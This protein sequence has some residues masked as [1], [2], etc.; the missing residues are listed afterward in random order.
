MAKTVA[1]AAVV[2]P[3]S[4]DGALPGRRRRR[5]PLHLFPL[6]RP[7]RRTR[8]CGPARS[9]RCSS[10][11]PPERR[12]RPIGR[13]HRCRSNSSR[14]ARDLRRPAGACRSTGPRTNA[15]TATAS[16]PLS[17]RSGWAGCVRANPSA[18]PHQSAIEAAVW[19]DGKLDVG[20][21]LECGI[22]GRRRWTTIEASTK[23]V[24]PATA[25][26]RNAA[27]RGRPPGGTA[28][29]PTAVIASTIWVPP[30][31]VPTLVTEIGVRWVTT[32]C[33]KASS[34]RC[35]ALCASTWVTSQPRP[36]ITASTRRK[37]ANTSPTTATPVRGRAPATTPGTGPGRVISSRPRVCTHRGDEYRIAHDDR[38]RGPRSSADAVA[39][40]SMRCTS[41][42]APSPISRIFASRSWTGNSFVKPYPP[43][44]WMA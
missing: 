17:T 23:R 15:G 7:R 38:P 22:A 11:S 28:R 41:A 13:R 43:C 1:E 27:S 8:R 16:T 19:P 20:G 39:A 10:T 3:A 29:R 14:A 21:A 37:A 35:T 5:L 6:A 31:S 34:S 26:A 4:P 9:A 40:I 33:S 36:R 25:T 24:S 44:T 12:V 18:S 42:G 2:T 30:R 32:P